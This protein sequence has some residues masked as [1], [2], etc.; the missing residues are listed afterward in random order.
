MPVAYGDGYAR[1]IRSGAFFVMRPISSARR[2]R[3]VLRVLLETKGGDDDTPRGI[4]PRLRYSRAAMP[5]D[6]PT[7]IAPSNATSGSEPENR[8]PGNQQGS[9]DED[10]DAIL[11]RRRRFIVAALSSVAGAA[12]GAGCEPSSSGTPGSAGSNTTPMPCLTVAVP[13]DPSPPSASSSTPPAPTP[14]P[15]PSPQPCLKVA[16]PKDSGR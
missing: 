6:E 13:T 8:S 10:Q 11:A 14:T 7:P 15:S 12:L 5:N 1:Q 2:R 16:A 9:G 3:M 4:R